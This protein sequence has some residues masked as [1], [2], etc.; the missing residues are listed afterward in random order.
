MLGDALMAESENGDK[1]LLPYAL[2]VIAALLG[3]TGGTLGSG[4]FDKDELSV[5]VQKELIGLERRLV[6]VEVK[7][8]LAASKGDVALLRV[9]MDNVK[10]DVFELQHRP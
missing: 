4:V 7:G 2:A 9:D 3:A 10:N 1:K 5:A 8:G 6:E